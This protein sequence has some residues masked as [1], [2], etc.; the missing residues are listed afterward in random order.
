[1][2]HHP[3]PGLRSESLVSGPSNYLVAYKAC[4]DAHRSCPGHR[5]D[6]RECAGE[7]A[8]A[9]RLVEKVNDHHQQI[10]DGDN[11]I[12]A[13]VECLAFVYLEYL[14]APAVLHEFLAAAERREYNRGVAAGAASSIVA[15]VAEG[16]GAYR[17]P[18]PP[19]R[20]AHH[21]RSANGAYKAQGAL[22][23]DGVQRQG[24]G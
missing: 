16:E 9:R 5:W 21:G 18:Q 15:W 3:P 24:G 20:A 19:L 14:S 23:G 2:D 8:G 7:I 12:S 11:E 10:T 6:G 22:R 17:S 1:M 4:D 13:P